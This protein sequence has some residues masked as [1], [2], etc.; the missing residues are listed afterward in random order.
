MQGAALMKNT[1]REGLIPN[2]SRSLQPFSQLTGFVNDDAYQVSFRNG[3]LLGHGGVAEESFG[4][5]GGDICGSSASL[6]PPKHPWERIFATVGMGNRARY[7]QI[8]TA[9]AVFVCWS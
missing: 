7:E 6:D 4:M 3:D 8:Y 9:S 2:R 5:V 1:E